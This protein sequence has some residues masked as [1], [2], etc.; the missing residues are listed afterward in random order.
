V[1]SVVVSVMAVEGGFDDD[2]GGL[3]VVVS[4]MAVD[5]GFDGDS[6]GLAVMAWR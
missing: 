5:G 2:G 1:V 6:G 4:V 3:A